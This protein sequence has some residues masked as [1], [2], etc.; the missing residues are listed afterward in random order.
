MASDQKGGVGPVGALLLMLVVVFVPLVGHIILSFIIVQDDLSSM[1]KLLW[2][3]VI[4][5]LPVIGPF[6]YLLLG[7]RRNRLLSRLSS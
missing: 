5:L 7:Q 6:L 2:L 4:W 3:V 1:E